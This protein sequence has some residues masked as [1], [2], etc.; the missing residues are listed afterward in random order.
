M[1]KR[2]DVT[3]VQAQDGIEEPEANVPVDSG[4]DRVMIVSASI[5]EGHNATGEALREA[6]G[7][8]W[9]Q[10]RV[11]WVDLLTEMG[12]G[13]GP[14]FR[15]VYTGSLRRLP[16]LYEF[17]Y[18][19]VRHYRW[20]QRFAKR[21]IG[22]WSGRTMARVVATGKPDMVLST[23]PMATTGLEWLRRNRGMPTPT[24]TWVAAFD[25][26]PSWVHAGV[27]VNFV[28]HDVA[29]P[30]AVSG[31]PDAVVRVSALPVAAAFGPGEREPARRE[32]GLPV[33]A[34]IALVSCGSLG[35]GDVAE[36]VR[37]LL[38]GGG[39]NMCV[40]VVTG[41][42]ETLRSTLVATFG[43]EPR[44]RVFGWVVNMPELLHATDVVVTNAG[45]AT[46]RE[47]LACG[48]SV[49]MH[50]PIAGHGRANGELMVRAGL[51]RLCEGAGALALAAR[52]L[53]Q[54]PARLAAGEQAI[55]AHLAAH[56]R[57][58]DSLA[59]LWADDAASAQ[60]S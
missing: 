12:F 1:A 21:L 30:A 18:R 11:D 37:E 43:D 17:F 16:W 55:G 20:L 49:L 15:G 10:A 32:L 38:R 31:V 9:P 41:R 58:T 28:M 29:V 40:L 3:T 23:Y 47:A 2:V 54:D 50:N 22:A 57:L 36:S 35:F 4:P 6:V 14:L 24:A 26:H 33:D 56:P 25:P 44:V 52:D 27:D 7:T 46:F 19:R 39:T 60:S 13:S 34:F 8:L 48:R 59:A 45:G 5:G 51:A 53:R 42:N